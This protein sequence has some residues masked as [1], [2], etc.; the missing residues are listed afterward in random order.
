MFAHFNSATRAYTILREAAS[1]DNNEATLN[2]WAAVFRIPNNNPIEKMLDI[3]RM[4][5]MLYKQLERVR[6]EMLRQ[7]IS[8]DKYNPVIDRLQSALNLDAPSNSWGTY[9]Q[10]LHSYTLDILAQYADL[11]EA[12][13]DVIPDEEIAKI[14]DI[15]NNLEQEVR[16]SKMPVDARSFV[17]YHISLLQNAFRAY[18]V[19]GIAAFIE[20]VSFANTNIVLSQDLLKKSATDPVFTTALQHIG[21][22]WAHIKNFSPDLQTVLAIIEASEIIVEGGKVVIGYLP[23]K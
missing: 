5:D 19:I 18:R 13:K 8:P 4:V 1:R 17:E 20:G 23:G 16:A 10:H 2:T 21:N 12:E 7:K 22:I 15:I 11:L 6:I 14:I 9:K 3:A